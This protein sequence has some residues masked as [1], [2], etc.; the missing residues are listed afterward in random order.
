MRSRA[1]DVLIGAMIGVLVTGAAS[2]Y[3]VGSRVSALEVEVRFLRKDVD[4]ALAKTTTFTP[5]Q[6]GDIAG[7]IAT[8]QDR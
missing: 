1:F 8:G 3:A 2:M 5:L 6:G 4:R 7:S